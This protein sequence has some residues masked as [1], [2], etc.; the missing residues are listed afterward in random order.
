MEKIF[1]EPAVKMAKM[2]MRLDFSPHS[3]KAG[4]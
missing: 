2:G 3:K 4:G 1:L